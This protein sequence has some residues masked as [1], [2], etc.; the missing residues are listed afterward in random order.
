MSVDF[1]ETSEAGSVQDAVV[2]VENPGPG[3]IRFL[4]VTF[5][6]IAPRQGGEE[7][8][9]PLVGP[10]A[11]EDHP[12]VAAVSPEPRAVSSDGLVYNFGPLPEGEEITI[13]FSLRI[14]AEIGPAANSLQV[15]DGQDLERARGVRLET[16][17]RR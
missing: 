12:A 6:T 17:V 4:A 5:A 7:F 11:P 16:L 13:T 8:P 1:P 2:E 15:G 14:P 3:D 10:G 9:I